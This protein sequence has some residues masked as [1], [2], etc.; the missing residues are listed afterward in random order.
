MRVRVAVKP[1]SRIERVERQPDGS[2]LVRVRARARE[3][4]ANAAV[5]KTVAGF[6][7]VPKSKVKLIAGGRSRSKLLEIP[8]Q[9]GPVAPDR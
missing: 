4:E 1:G 7:G 9:P 3:G 5:V 6:Y 2:L 8:A